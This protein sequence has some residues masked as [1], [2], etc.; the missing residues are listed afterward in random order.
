MERVPEV[1]ADTVIVVALIVAVTTA[2]D[3]AEVSKFPLVPGATKVT[4]SVPL[5]I[6]TLLRVR[7]ASPVPP[8]A[9]GKVPTAPVLRLKVED[10]HTCA[11]PV[12][13]VL[14]TVCDALTV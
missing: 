13:V 11:V 1:T 8:L 14:D 3:A 7:V 6:T 9:T 4:F 12:M 5:P 10:C 2:T